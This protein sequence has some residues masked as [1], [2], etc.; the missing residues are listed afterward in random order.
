[1]I[2]T[3]KKVFGIP[4]APSGFGKTSKNQAH[5]LVLSVIRKASSPMPLENIKRHMART[6]QGCAGTQVDRLHFAIRAAMTP[7]DLWMK[8][9]DIYQAVAMQHG[10]TEA[11]R[12]I[13]Q[14]L[15]CFDH[16]LPAH[17]LSK[18]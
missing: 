12:R 2:L 17:Q 1:M 11:S 9:T 14:L 8:R 4:F 6:L 5:E 15:S 7:A 13:N 10:Q 16:W 18:V 3:M